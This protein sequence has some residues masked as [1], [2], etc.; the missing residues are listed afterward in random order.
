MRLP[1]GFQNRASGLAQPW[2]PLA[3]FWHPPG[4]EILKQIRDFF[5]TA[6]FCP[7][8]HLGFA[9]EINGRQFALHDELQIKWSRNSTQLFG[10]DNERVGVEGSR[11]NLG[12]PCDEPDRYSGKD[13]RK[14]RREE[15][16]LWPRHLIDLLKNTSDARGRPGNIRDRSGEE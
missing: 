9:C 8:T 7:G 15:N 1:N 6:G 10:R 2:G 16:G 3:R 12:R 14:K 5:G 4:E 11:G 13:G